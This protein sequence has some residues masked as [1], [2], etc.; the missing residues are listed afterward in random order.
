MLTLAT[1]SEQNDTYFDVEHSTNG[2]EFKTI[3]NVKGQGTAQTVTNYNFEHTAPIAGINYYRLKQVD[4]DGA[5]TYSP[6]QSIEFGKSD[7]VIKS[8][9]VKEGLDIIV[10][11]MN[12]TQVNIFNWWG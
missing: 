5:F 8:N 12:A 7:F 3:G 10:N 2:L 6:V 1:A 11:N 4:F 9:L